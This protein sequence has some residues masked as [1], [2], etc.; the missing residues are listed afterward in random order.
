MSRGILPLLVGIALGLAGGLTYAWVIDPVQ[1]TSTSPAA[2]RADFQADYLTLIASAYASTRDLDRARARLAL[3]SDPNPAET[4]GALAQARLASG[5]PMAEAQALA[6]LAG[7]LGVRP[8]PLPTSGTPSPGSR[9][10]GSP[11]VAR[12]PTV[13]PSPTVTRTPGA[14]FRVDSREL[15]CDIDQ[16]IPRLRV[17]VFDSA[18]QGVPGV[19]VLVVWEDGQDHFFTGLKPELGSGFGDFTMTEGVTYTVRLAESDALATGLVAETCTEDGETFPGSW[20]LVFVQPE[21]S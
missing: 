4:L 10:S 17:R 11:T 6:L 9:P 12:S 18:G 16:Q 2:L 7:D 1:F 14:P 13:R 15:V 3:F 5:G 21:E 19:E 20:E 8:S